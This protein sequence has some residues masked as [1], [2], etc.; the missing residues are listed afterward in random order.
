M[1]MAIHKTEAIV[2]LRRDYRETSFL[3]TLFTLDFGK[4]N[5][6]AKGAR[7]KIDKFGTSFLPLS[8]NRIVFYEKNRSDLHIISQADL[9]KN[10]D[11][12]GKKIEKLTFA[13]Y[14]LELISATMPVAQVNKDIFL[15][16]T[17]FLNILNRA[18]R[19]DNIVQIFEIKFLNLSGFKPRF[20]CCVSCENHIL[21][22]SRFS[23]ILGGL[24]CPQCFHADIGARN[25]MKGTI[26]SVNHIEK[27]E[28]EKISNFKMTPSVD[29][30][31]KQFLRSFIDFHIGQKFNALEFLKKIQVAYV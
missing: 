29:Q 11:N 24:L 6:Q 9:I 1:I 13:T 21:E 3:L 30:E 20:D 16:I 8:Y 7:R 22:Q 28:L 12:I 10:F 27:M 15:L 14:F 23:C 31:L 26:A 5:A 4:M 2:L 17:D 25:V 18:E 19:I